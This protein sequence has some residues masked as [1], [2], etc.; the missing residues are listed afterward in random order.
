[1]EPTRIK[2]AA[3]WMVVMFSVASADLLGLVH[4]GA[5]EKI[6]AGDFGFSITPALLLFSVLMTVPTLMIF[7][8]QVLPVQVN[9]WLN[10]VAALLTTLFVI[11]GGTAS[12][13]YVFFAMIERV[14]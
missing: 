6:L 9:R 4:P 11:G 10:S 14:L 7:L 5:L 13:S 12:L 8:S 2:L 1:M 3:L